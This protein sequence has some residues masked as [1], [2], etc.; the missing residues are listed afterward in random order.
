MGCLPVVPDAL[1]YPEFIPP[2]YRYDNSGV[3]EQQ[4][5]SATE[6]I[7]GIVAARQAS[8]ALPAVDLT[9]VRASH[10][11]ADWLDHLNKLL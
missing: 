2:D 1:A 4:A 9:A 8:S 3:I 10:R 11:R 6:R 5:A 7:L